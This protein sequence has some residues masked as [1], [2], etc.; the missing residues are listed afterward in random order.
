MNDLMICVSYVQSALFLLSSEACLRS[1]ILD[2]EIAEN[3]KNNCGLCCEASTYSK[4]LW[5]LSLFA[6]LGECLVLRA[7][8]SSL[9]C[10]GFVPDLSVRLL[11]GAL[12]APWIPR[13]GCLPIVSGVVWSD[14]SFGFT[15]PSFWVPAWP[16]LRPSLCSEPLVALYVAGKAALSAL[17][18]GWKLRLPGD[19]ASAVYSCLNPSFA[20]CTFGSAETATT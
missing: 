12:C 5:P 4:A 20:H 15:A 7:F 11:W 13:S 19:V 6:L 16:C 2:V 3:T 1:D 14:S 17:A 8:V 18:G 9:I 10:I